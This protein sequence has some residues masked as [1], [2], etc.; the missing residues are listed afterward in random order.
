MSMGQGSLPGPVP[1]IPAPSPVFD[2]PS[3]PHHLPS[4]YWDL[5]SRGLGS[6]KH[7]WTD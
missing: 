2:C 3:G 4:F 1:P 5:R 7:I 6:P